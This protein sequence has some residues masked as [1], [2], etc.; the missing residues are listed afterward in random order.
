MSTPEDARLSKEEIAALS[1]TFQAAD[2]PYGAPSPGDPSARPLDLVGMTS[3]AR[4][5]GQAPALDLIHEEFARH[6]ETLL[7]RATR[8]HGSCHAEKV[9]TQSLSLIHI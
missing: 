1:R 3:I 9:D 4:T 6:L 7:E 5:T 2:D 8:E